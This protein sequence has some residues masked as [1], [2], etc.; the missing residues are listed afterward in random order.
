MRYIGADNRRP[1]QRQIANRVERLVAHEFVTVAQALGVEHAVAVNGDG[2][3]QA[4]AKR[5]AGRPK[6][7]HVGDETER[8]RL[9]DLFP[10]CLGVY[11]EMAPLPAYRRHFEIDLD[12]DMEAMI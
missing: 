7:L 6:F 5:E 8:A 9:G 2:V 10:E 11:F 3:F 4:G 1:R 12:I